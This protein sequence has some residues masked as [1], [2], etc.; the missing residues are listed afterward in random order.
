MFSDNIQKEKYL[1][2]INKAKSTNVYNFF[3]EVVSRSQDYAYD[4]LVFGKAKKTVGK[5]ILATGH[6]VTPDE[7]ICK[8]REKLGLPHFPPTTLTYKEALQSVNIITEKTGLKRIIE[9]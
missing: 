6:S 3:I 9:E 8:L 5:N 7:K 4:N 2:Y 1:K